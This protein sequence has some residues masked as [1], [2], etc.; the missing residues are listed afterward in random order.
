MRPEQKEN[1]MSNTTPQR[2]ILGVDVSKDKLDIFNLNTGEYLIIQNNNKTIRTFLKKTRKLFDNVLIVVE[3]TGG[4]EK[5]MLHTCQELG[6]ST[7]VAHPSRIF[8]FAKQKG[9]LAKT[10]K[11]DAETIAE[12]AYQEHVEPNDADF[13]ANDI[14]RELNNR[15]AQIVDDLHDE[16]CRLSRPLTPSVKR[17]I[18]RK[19]SFLEKEKEI[20]ES[21][22]AK[23]IQDCPEKSVK[24]KRLLTFK[25]V[26][27]AIA[28]GLVCLVPELGKLSR[29]QIA[30]IIGV[31]PKNHDSGKKCGKR[32]IVGGR[33][34]ARR[35]L[36]MGA[37]VAIRYNSGL[38]AFYEKLVAKGKPAKV[39]IVAVMRKM[40]ITLNAMV[41]DNKDWLPRS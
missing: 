9:Y 35:L 31:A 7:H 3:S 4:L 2:I 30:A 28:N 23:T 29:S 14:L 26:G 38:K 41:R 33:F 8:Y 24:V 32:R 37:L 1:L 34:N 40:T 13:K 5:Y 6:V 11:K 22:I 15:R 21:E 16:K 39:G 10:D 17:S 25:G 20:I 19:I 27:P 18:K 36:Y 12:Y